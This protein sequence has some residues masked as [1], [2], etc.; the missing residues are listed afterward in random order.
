MTT[1]MNGPDMRIDDNLG[2]RVSEANNS[3]GMLSL[4]ETCL[5]TKKDICSVGVFFFWFHRYAIG[6]AE[7]LNGFFR[8]YVN[9]RM[10]EGDP[11]TK[12]EGILRTLNQ[13]KQ[14]YPKTTYQHIQRRSWPVVI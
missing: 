4:Q 1:R 11:I 13:S 9:Y 6:S 12:V 7:E 3:K 5:A 14:Y 2:R 10:R 8:G